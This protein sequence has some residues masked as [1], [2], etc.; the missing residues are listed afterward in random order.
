MEEQ[1][2]VQAVTKVLE[3]ARQPLTVAGII[4]VTIE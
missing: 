1:K 3:E 2:I 4:Q